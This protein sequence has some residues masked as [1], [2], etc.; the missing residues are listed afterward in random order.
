MNESTAIDEKVKKPKE[1]MASLDVFRGLAVAGMIFVNMVSLAAIGKLD[2]SK[3]FVYEKELNNLGWLKNLYLWIDHANWHNSWNLADF[4]FPFFLHIV[5]M[6]LVF[7]FKGYKNR[8]NKNNQTFTK[9]DIFI[10]RLKRFAILFTLGLLLNGTVYAVCKIP[11]VGIFNFSS[12]RIMGVLQR[13]ALVDFSAAMLILCFPLDKSKKLWGIAAGILVG[14]WLLLSFVPAP[15]APPQILSFVDSKDFNIAAYIDRLIIPGNRLSE[16]TYD[17]EGILSTIPAIVSVLLGYFHS[18]WVDENKPY[19][20]KDSIS[21]AILATGLITVGILWGSFFPINKNLWTSSY[22]LFMAGWAI[23]TFTFF[24]ELIDVQRIG[25]VKSTLD[26][27]KNPIIKASGLAKLWILPL[28]WMGVSPLVAFIGSVLMIK[29]TKRNNING[30]GGGA[31]SIYEYLVKTTFGWSGWGNETLLFALA[32]VL[33]WFSL[34]YV[35]YRNRWF[36]KFNTAKSQ[37]IK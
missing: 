15:G 35:I 20:R 30:C 25:D 7:S 8:E 14:Y 24:Y 18:H 10:D 26:E 23:I 1:R 36:V 29:I 12:V 27:D 2:E 4:V 28:S 6:S 5:G 22:V 21:M 9:Y 33:L 34:C 32:T 31:T 17:A 16:T 13:I 3:E 19:K 11:E 37:T